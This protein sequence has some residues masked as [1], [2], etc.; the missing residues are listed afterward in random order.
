MHNF[1][2]FNSHLSA[3]TVAG[4][5]VEVEAWEKDPAMP[6]PF[7]TVVDGANVYL[8]VPFFGLADS[9]ILE[10]TERQVKLALA[11]EEARE[12]E[13][14]EGS[15]VHDT[16]SPAVLITTGMDFSLQ[17]YVFHSMINILTD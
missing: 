15:M 3:P 9:P 7:E 12:L 14:G 5:T 8:F 17:Q 13:H 4:W 6:N 2:E 10:I 16:L 11:Q 1:E